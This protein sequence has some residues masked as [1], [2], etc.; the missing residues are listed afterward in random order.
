MLLS[1]NAV[2]KGHIIILDGQPYLVLNT[3]HSHMGRG[4]ATLRLKIK[5][6][7]DGKVLDRGFSGNDKLE[8]A[9]VTT[10]KASFLYKD[11]TDAYF[12][13]VQS[14]EQFSISLDQVEDK[15]NF[16]TEG[17]EINIVIFENKPI[18]IVLPPKISLKVVEA[19]PGVRGDT[20]QGSVSKPVT[21]ETGLIINAPLFVKTGDTIKVNTETGEYVERV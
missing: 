13:D 7:I 9:D 16:L 1:L 12:M 8:Q 4:K 11:E 3:Q 19:A 10:N 2:R 20:A 6:L 18:D 21:L 5:S 15:I 14:Y 17:T